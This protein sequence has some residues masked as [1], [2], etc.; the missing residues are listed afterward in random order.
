MRVL[1]K[2]AVRGLGEAGE[3]KKVAD[4]YAANYL[5]PRGLAVPATPSV[6]KAYEAQAQVESRKQ[7]QETD[8]AGRIADQ[9]QG[10]VLTVTAKAGETGKLYGSITSGDIASGLEMET[11]RSVDKRKVMLDGSIRELGKYKVPIKLM[12]EVISE[13]TVIVEA[14][15]A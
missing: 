4:G 3:V 14:E 15:S 9:L 13:I 8:A 12:P 10:V 7:Q 5:V 11:G 6:L 1:L 2:R